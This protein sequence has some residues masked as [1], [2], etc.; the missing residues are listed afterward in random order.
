MSNKPLSLKQV[1]K[2]VCG[3]WDA[4][5]KDDK[6]EVPEGKFI[7]EFSDKRMHRK[8]KIYLIMMKKTEMLKN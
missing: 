1:D 5:I 2:G 4:V 3:G 6:S 8:I 7:Y